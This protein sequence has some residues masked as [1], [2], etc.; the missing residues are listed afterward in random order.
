MGQRAPAVVALL[1][2]V[3]ASLVLL[4]VVDDDFWGPRAVAS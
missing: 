3:G 2:I 4:D 1:L